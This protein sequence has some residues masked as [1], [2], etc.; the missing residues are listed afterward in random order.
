MSA[1]DEIR[2]RVLSSLI[3]PLRLQSSDWIES[4]IRKASGV[5][6]CGATLVVSTRDRRCHQ[7][8]RDRTHHLVKAVA[9][10]LHNV[11]DRPAS[12]PFAAAFIQRESK[13]FLV[14]DGAGFASLRQRSMIS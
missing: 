1:L 12:A 2:T 9:H 13:L 10:R 5:T 14:D 11:V 3:P 4:N 7:R 6:G 8:S